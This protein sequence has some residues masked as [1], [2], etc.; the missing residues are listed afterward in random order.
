MTAFYVAVAFQVVWMIAGQVFRFDP[1]PY[2]FL[3]FLSSQT[4]LLLMFVIMVGQQVIGRSAARRAEQTYLNAEGVLH[5]CERLQAH[6]RAQDD[7]IRHVVESLRP[8]EPG[9]RSNKGPV[10]GGCG[11]PVNR[12][13]TA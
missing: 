8:R 11:L 7:A 1:Y 4:Q 3:L 6:L 9:A 13:I 10:G 12:P 2:L 5:A